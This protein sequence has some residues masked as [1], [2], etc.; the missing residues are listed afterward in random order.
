L[1]HDESDFVS[2]VGEQLKEKPLKSCKMLLESMGPML[3]ESL[4]GNTNQALGVEKRC[5]GEKKI[6][7]SKREKVK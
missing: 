1:E 6:W 2:F 4:G 7:D 3:A 5:M